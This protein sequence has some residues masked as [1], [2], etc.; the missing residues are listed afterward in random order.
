MRQPHKATCLPRC[1]A[2]RGGTL[3][4]SQEKTK[5]NL[6]IPIYLSRLPNEIS[7]CLFHRGEIS[8]FYLSRE[9]ASLYISLGFHWDRD[10]QV[11]RGLGELKIERN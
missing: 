6:C 10:S 11:R 7:F 1:E 9:I 8:V 2:L 4:Q 3:L 5:S